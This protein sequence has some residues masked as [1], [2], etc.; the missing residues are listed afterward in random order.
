MLHRTDR[1]LA[2]KVA[3]VTGASRRIGRAVALGLAQAGADVVVH[4]RQSRDEVE[5]VANEVRALGQRA[6]VA[7]GDV[8]DE[9]AVM[10]VGGEPVVVPSTA[11]VVTAGEKING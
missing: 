6:A 3:M 7:L 11:G 4:A 10:A 9:A 8:T 5:A 2:G 1:P